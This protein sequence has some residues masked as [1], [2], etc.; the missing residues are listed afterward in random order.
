MTY[1]IPD[2]QAQLLR[3]TLFLGQQQLQYAWERELDR[4]DQ[5]AAKRAWQAWSDARHLLLKLDLA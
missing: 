3:L 1:E 4:G 2:E 5:E